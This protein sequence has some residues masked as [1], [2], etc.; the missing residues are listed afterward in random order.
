MALS[1]KQALVKALRMAPSDR[2]SFRS[3]PLG[4][5]WYFQRFGRS[6]M[7]LGSSAK[8]VASALE[9]ADWDAVS[10]IRGDA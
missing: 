1:S 9:G 2:L 3:G 5:G 8:E 4:R 7:Y 6:E 10:A